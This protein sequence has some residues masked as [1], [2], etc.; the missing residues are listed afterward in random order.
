MLPRKIFRLNS[1]LIAAFIALPKECFFFCQIMGKV[2]TSVLKKTCQSNSGP[3]LVIN[4]VPAVDVG[5]KLDI[6][7]NDLKKPRQA[8]GVFLKNRS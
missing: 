7:L 6:L 2:C 1:A 4:M 5:P 8:Q 3:I